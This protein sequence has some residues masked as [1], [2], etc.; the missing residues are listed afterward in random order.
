MYIPAVVAVVVIRG[1]RAPRR[2]SLL[3]LLRTPHTVIS[4]M[5]TTMELT[6]TPMITPT[7]T[8]ADNITK[9]AGKT[10]AL[11]GWNVM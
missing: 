2:P 10:V 9:V 1:A 11:D 4:R 6:D 5:K 3:L 7:D 8:E